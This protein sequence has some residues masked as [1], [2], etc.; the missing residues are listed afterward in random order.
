[1]SERKQANVKW[2]YQM[3]G[4]NVQG[5]KAR[6]E[7]VSQIKI[8]TEARERTHYEIRKSKIID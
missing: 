7:V 4:A 8:V 6:A 5:V 1:M 3:C 2:Q